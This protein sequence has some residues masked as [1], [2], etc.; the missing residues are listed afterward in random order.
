MPTPNPT[1]EA[2]ERLSKESREI[3]DQR[4][5]ASRIPTE[6]LRERQEAV[7]HKLPKPR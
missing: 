3:Q 6:R 7:R 1:K 5:R 4:D 2:L